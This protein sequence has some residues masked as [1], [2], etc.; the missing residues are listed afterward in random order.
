[1]K[2]LVSII[3]CLFIFQPSNISAQTKIPVTLERCVDGDTAVFIMNDQETKFRFLAINTPESVH[4]T[5]EVEDYGKEA[6]EITC[7][8]LT[9]A[10]TIEIE[11]DSGSNQTDKYQRH[12]GWIWLDGQL[13]QELLV[14]N[15]YAQVAYI[16]GNY[17]YTNNLCYTQS[18]AR[19]NQLGIW[20]D[21]SLEEG[22]CSKIDYQNQTSINQENTI[23]ITTNNSPNNS[24]TSPTHTVT[25][26][27]DGEIYDQIEIE[28]NQTLDSMVETTIL[29]TLFEGWY[30]DDQKFDFTTPITADIILEG[31]YQDIYQYLGWAIFIIL[32]LF[33]GLNRKTKSKKK[34][35]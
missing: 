15:G 12:L 2:Y 4:P 1:M 20:Q 32:S 26:M 27:L 31:Q 8:L 30:L 18:L 11:Y 34:R 33:L 28:T 35:T 14:S 23:D 7:S 16:Y 29:T 3:V 24:D 21:S 13:L 19:Q 6:S 25:L 5:K 10:T 22:Y 17:Q 9:N